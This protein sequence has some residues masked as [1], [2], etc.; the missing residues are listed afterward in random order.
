M[1]NDGSGLFC[2]I[3]NRPKSQIASC[4]A[5]KERLY[6]RQ[7][8]SGTTVPKKRKGSASIV[9][10]LVSFLLCLALLLSAASFALAEESHGDLWIGNYTLTCWIDFDSIVAQYFNDYNDTPFF[11]WLEEQTGVHVEFQY[12][13]SEQYEQQMNLM[14]ATHQ[15]TDIMYYPESPNGPEAAVEDGLFADLNQY[16]DLMPNYYTMLDDADS[17]TTAWEW[18]EERDVFWY[19]PQGAFHDICNTVNGYMWCASQIWPDSTG[20]YFGPYVRKDWLDELGLQVPATI[21]ELETVLAAFRTLGD[22]VI[23]MNLNPTGFDTVSY[24]LENAFNFQ[25]GWYTVDNGVVQPGEGCGTQG[26]REYL[27]LMADWYKKGYI[28]P[29][30]MNRDDAGVDALVLSDRLGVVMPGWGSYGPDQLEYQY[31]GPDEDFA[32][33]A[34]PM[35]VREPGQQLHLRFGDDCA[36]TNYFCINGGADEETKR[37]AAQWLDKWYTRE[38]VLRAY[39]G[40]ENE[41]YVLDEEGHPYY[42]KYFYANRDD[43]ALNMTKLYM[44]SKGG[45]WSSRAMSLAWLLNPEDVEEMTDEEVIAYQKYGAGKTEY[46]ANQKT[47][48]SADFCD[49]TGVIGYVTFSGDGWDEAYTPYNDAATTFE[50]YVL[51]VIIGED[52]L[53]RY[54]DVC[55][56]CWALG[57]ELSRELFQAAYNAQHGLDPDYGMEYVMEIDR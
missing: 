17:S 13:N 21:G 10:K 36:P 11:Q 51:R 33:T 6:W 4:G 44:H 3:L 25:F 7:E 5:L 45:Y 49:R 28:D 47:W 35:L 39:Y 40:I 15:I 53:D 30:F 8:G 27:A 2:H 48:A 22:D 50:A 55:H 16:R 24:W 26:L 34:L 1:K 52:S 12:Y 20:V 42:T 23:P 9:K 31:E 29:N 56:T 43:E 46:A 38:V 14:L 37:V 57:F 54:E 19:G 32:L 18:G 41:T